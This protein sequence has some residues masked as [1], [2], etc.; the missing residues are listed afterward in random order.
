MVNLFAYCFDCSANRNGDCVA[1]HRDGHGV[2]TN[3]LTGN[4]GVIDAR[5]VGAITE[6]AQAAQQADSKVVG[7]PVAVVCIDLDRT[8]GDL[9]VGQGSGSI[10]A[11]SQQTEE[12]TGST[13]ATGDLQS[14][15]LEGD[16]L[17]H[18]LSHQSAKQTGL[19]LVDVSLLDGDVSDHMAIAFDAASK[20]TMDKSTGPVCAIL[21]EVQIVKQHVVAVGIGDLAELG[22]LADMIPQPRRPGCNHHG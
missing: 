5:Q 1:I 17:D 4:A 20:F 22:S 15:V 9:N 16:I 21:R 14:N 13:S 12:G 19:G 2:F 6:I 11:T 18:S 10:N 7:S 8:I 3:L